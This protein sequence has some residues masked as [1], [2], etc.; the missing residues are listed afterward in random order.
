MHI[1]RCLSVIAA[2][3]SAPG[4]WAQSPA[5]PATNPALRADT[6]ADHNNLLPLAENALF[7]TGLSLYDRVAYANQVQD[8]KKVYS[9]TLASTWDHLR[10]Q[11]WVHDQ[12]PFN[13]NQFAH[14]YQGATMY[15]IARTSGHR[16][17]SSLIQADVGSFIWKMAGETDPPSINDM[18]TTGQA[19]AL[20]GE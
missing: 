15:A 13:V 7:L 11:T 3:A 14:P 4:A 12:D 6:T 16:F 5:P 20:L 10:R 9:S 17:W 1:V 19:G 18:I 2:L 8:G